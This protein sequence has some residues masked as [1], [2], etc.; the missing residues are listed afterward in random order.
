MKNVVLEVE[1]CNSDCFVSPILPHFTAHFIY[2]ICPHFSDQKSLGTTPLFLYR[3]L[4]IFQI[5]L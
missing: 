2:S 5:F 1:A 3:I 4:I